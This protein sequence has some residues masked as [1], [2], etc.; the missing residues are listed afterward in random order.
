MII[1]WLVIY[2]DAAGVE[3]QK[4]FPALAYKQAAATEK[5]MADRVR[6]SILQGT[7]GPRSVYLVALSS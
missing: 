5:E 7:P 2:T 6:Q 1:G 3:F 4:E